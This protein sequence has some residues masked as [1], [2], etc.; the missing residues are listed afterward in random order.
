MITPF[1]GYQMILIKKHGRYAFL[2]ILSGLKANAP[3]RALLDKGFITAATEKMSSKNMLK[4][5]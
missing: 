1:L 5:R 2:A 3:M 4:I